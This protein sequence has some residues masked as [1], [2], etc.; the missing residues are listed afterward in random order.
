MADSSIEWTD[1]VWNPTRGCSRISPG[2]GGAKGEGG[3]YAE[4][5]AARFSGPGQPYEG[6]VR[7]G[8]QGPRWTGVVRLARN[9]LEE[10]LRWRKPK[11]IFVNSMS[12]LF[13]ENLS[14]HDIANVFSVMESARSRG[15]TFQILTKR[16]DR[17]QR[18]VSDWASKIDYAAGPGE[19]ARRYS[20]V[21]LGVSAENQDYADERISRLLTTP[22]SVRFV[23][24]EP[25]LGSMSLWAFLRGE[26]RD[27]SLAALGTR[28][29]PGLDWVIV[30]GESGP[31]ARAFDIQWMRDVVAQC[32]V[33]GVAVF[34][35][36]HVTEWPS[37]DWP[38]EFPVT[39]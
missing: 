9:K 14:D 10:P 2:C 34:C 33:A 35:K 7:I 38:R 11:R 28:P 17:M 6:L 27:A 1:K 15:H 32:R 30:G 23:S 18:W 37:G 8:K 29:M 20:H 39:A 26:H 12:D 31:G 22:A 4:R 24:Y 25:A 36:Q 16:A 13:H 21:W 5:Q 19:Y 3:C